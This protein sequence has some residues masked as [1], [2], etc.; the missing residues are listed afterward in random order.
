MFNM[1]AENGWRALLVLGLALCLVSLVKFIRNRGQLPLPPKPKGLPI[2]GNT[3]EFVSAAKGNTVHLLLQKWAKEYGEVIRVQIGSVTEYYINSDRAVKALMDKASA[4]TSQRPRWIVSNELLCNQWNVLLLNASDPRWKLQRKLIHSEMAS[5]AMADAA[6]PM[7]YYETSKFLD[8]VVHDPTAG[9]DKQDLW[10]QIGRYTY[11]NFAKQ[12]FGFDV[13]SLEDPAIEYIH[14]SGKRQIEGTLP[15]THLVDIMPWMN[16]LPLW[17]KPWER[18]A[19][20]YFKDDVQW[21]R[22]RMIKTQMLPFDHPAFLR[23]ILND[24]KRCGISCDD[25]AAFLSLQMILGAADTVKAQKEIDFIVGNRIPTWDDLKDIPIVRCLMKE[26]WRWRPPVALGHPHTTTRDL[27]YEG[28]RIPKGARLHLNG[29]A[30]QHDPDRHYD[31]DE[32]RPERW[33]ND[34]S[35]TQQ[36]INS[37]DPSLRDHFAFGAG[38]R[39][40]PGIHI[41]ERSLAV[42]IM[43]ILWAFDVMLKP[44]VRGKGTLDPKTY[45]GFMPGNP[46]ENLPVCLVP[47]SKERGADVERSGR[48]RRRG[49]IELRD[50]ACTLCP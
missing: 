2:I 10:T 3:I 39:I 17:L 11:S 35:T 13:P 9:T 45:A 38:R 32:F 7:L 20:A 1:L 18:R 50:V 47:R 25:E 4:Q 15:G 19:R 30:I 48:G 34:H 23:H 44:S 36:S 8:E 33:V 12:T 40:C 49:G 29:W 28:L 6:L 31:P 16:N 22:T 42:A 21:A 27:E 5:P 41:A 46:G 43:R 37:P 26:V 24:E 14:N